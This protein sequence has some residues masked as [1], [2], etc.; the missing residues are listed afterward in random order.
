MYGH[1][2]IVKYTVS[3]PDAGIKLT[4]HLYLTYIVAGFFL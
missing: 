4:L 3:L 2:Y 1:V